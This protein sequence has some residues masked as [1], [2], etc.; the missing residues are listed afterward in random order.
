MSGF[1]VVKLLV[2]GGAVKTVIELRQSRPDIHKYLGWM[3]TPN[4]RSAVKTLIR[5]GCES[6]HL[7]NAAFS[8]FDERLYLKMLTKWQAVDYPSVS[9]VTV[10]DVVGDAR[11]TSSL[12][13]SWRDRVSSLG[14][15]L[16]YVGQDG[17]EDMLLPWADFSCLFIGG[18]TEWKLSK[19]ASDVALEAKRQGKLLHVGRVNS[20]KRLR[21][22]YYLGADSVDGTGYSKYNQKELVKA[23]EYVKGLHEQLSLF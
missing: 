21:Y 15:P 20:Q 6:I 3:N 11:T 7:D 8:N 17:C 1:T 12:F 16:A 19:S 18:T 5:Q 13:R 2:N 10:P 22:A 9:W 4:I 23:L 14:H